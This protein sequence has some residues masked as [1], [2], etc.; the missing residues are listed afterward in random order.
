MNQDNLKKI[1]S[2]SIGI[3][4]K[5]GFI[6]HWHINNHEAKDLGRDLWCEGTTYRI[7]PFERP[8]EDFMGQCLLEI[9]RTCHTEF[10]QN[11][12]YVEL[13]QLYVPMMKVDDS[14]V[15]LHS[16]DPILS[17]Q[18]LTN[19]IAK[20]PPMSF[21]AFDFS[22]IQRG[23]YEFKSIWLSLSD[24]E[25]HA[26][27]NGL[28]HQT[29]KI[30]EVILAPVYQLNF[31]HQEER[32]TMMSW[33]DANL[34]GITSTPL[35]EDYILTGKSLVYSYPLFTMLIMF[36]LLC[37][38]C[39][40]TL[41]CIYKLW[42][43]YD[44]NIILRLIAFCIPILLI[45]TIT[46]YVIQGLVKIGDSIFL[47]IEKLI[48]KQMQLKYITE[49]LE[50]K[51]TIIRERFPASRLRMPRVD[52]FPFDVSTM[53]EHLKFYKYFAENLKFRFNYIKTIWDAD[54]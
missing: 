2:E 17:Y 39:F 35:P 19:G 38:S 15:C 42:M 26:M 43:H 13:K 54:D 37:A 47:A 46:Y 36:L 11:I 45:Y 52:D 44:W 49:S 16:Q 34:S 18:F 28:H 7:A 4:D 27:A 20:L 25:Y 1:Q 22:K 21:A 14:Y 53:E 5:D 29:D 31:K 33:G 3:A 12:K 8:K 50:K 32:Y 9:S 24:V 10:L 30:P 40:M 6:G 23:L 51:E 41:F 48:S